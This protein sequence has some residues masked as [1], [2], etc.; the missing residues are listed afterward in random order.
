LRVSQLRPVSV[1]IGALLVIASAL[2][3]QSPERTLAGSV[4]LLKGSVER[5]L[6]GQWV[7]LHR[8]GSDGAGPLD[9]MRTSGT[10]RFSFRYRPSGDSTALYFA[11]TQYGGIAYFT[12]PAPAKD[13]PGGVIAVFDTTSSNVPL[14]VASRHIV[15]SA[16]DTGSSRVV[17]ELFVLTNSGD[18][19]LVTG[20]ARRSTFEVLLPRGAVEPRAA[21]GD[22]PNEAMEFTAGAMRM[23]APVAPGTKRVSFTYRMPVT[24]GPIEFAA[25]GPA[26]L[27]EVLIEDPAGTASGAGIHEGAPTSAAG[28][29]FRRFVGE[30]FAGG[31]GVTVFAPTGVNAGLGIVASIVIAAAAAMVVLL[32]RA[33]RS[34][35]AL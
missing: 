19:T 11:S 26:E 10:G 12:T 22:V 21:E 16:P 24:A 28:R 27:L 4:A 30:K 18:R 32:V 1:A 13:A 3:A 8:V 34:G 14:T 9:S 2:D 29:T 35:V 20:S 6:G 33:L 31:G 5:P 23:S 7:T 25:A 17:L 15:V